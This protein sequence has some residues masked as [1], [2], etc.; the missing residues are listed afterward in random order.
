MR[1]TITN[2]EDCPKTVW[3]TEKE[4]NADVRIVAR[5]GNEGY[6]VAY[7]FPHCERWT[8]YPVDANGVHDINDSADSLAVELPQAAE[9][10]GGGQ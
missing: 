10:M 2:I 4:G 5:M 7:R 1:A 3:K 9:V 8:S 6:L